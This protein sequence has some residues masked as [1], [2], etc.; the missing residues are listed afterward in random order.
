MLRAVGDGLTV[1]GLQQRVGQEWPAFE[2]LL[3]AMVGRRL[4]SLD[5]A[6]AGRPAAWAP[7]G[8]RPGRLGR[9]R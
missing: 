4:L 7:Y 6:Q 2:G 8:S 1:A 9:G 5:A 3:F